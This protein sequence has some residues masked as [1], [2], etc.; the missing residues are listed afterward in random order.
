MVCLAN[1]AQHKVLSECPTPDVIMIDLKDFSALGV[2][3]AS[4]DSVLDA[5]EIS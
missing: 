1:G 4:S 5:R 3:S 2:V